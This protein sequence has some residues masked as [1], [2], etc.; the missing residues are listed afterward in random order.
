[1]AGTSG[2]GP[3]D[4]APALAIGEVLGRIF[5]VELKSGTSGKGWCDFLGPKG[6]F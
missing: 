1:M 2:K 6:A 5:W 4:I 3:R